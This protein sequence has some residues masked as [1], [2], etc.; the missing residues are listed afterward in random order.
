MN[1]GRHLKLFSTEPARGSHAAMRC[2]AAEPLEFE[3]NL[4]L[5]DT[6]FFSAGNEEAASAL[7][8]DSLLLQ[9]FLSDLLHTLKW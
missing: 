7:S 5:P 6:N 2:W 3:S 9:L 8:S 1:I 4:E